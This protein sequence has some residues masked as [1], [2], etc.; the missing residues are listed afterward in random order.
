MS[1]TGYF[2]TNT[3][4]KQL[5][6]WSIFI[7]LSFIWGSSFILIKTGMTFLSPYN[8][9][10]IRII[11]SGI[12][13]LPITVRHIR[14]IPVSKLGLVFLSGVL[15]SLLPAYLFCAA[16]TKINSALAGMLNSLTPIFAI[17]CGALFFTSKVP[18][19]KVAGIVIAFAG[20]ILLLF[21]QGFKENSN[22]LYMCFAIIATIL[23]GININMVHKYLGNIRSLAIAS[24]ALSLCAIPATAVLFI[25]GFFQLPATSSKYVNSVVASVVLGIAGTAVATILF[26]ILVKRAG[27]IFSSMVTYGI[28]FIAILW[29]FVAH[30]N[31]TWKELA[32][33][34][35][36]LAGVYIANRSSKVIIG[37]QE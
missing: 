23:Y 4:N 32:S 18:A 22:I 9:A 12:V 31:I 25:S 26:Y 2:C 21:S 8:V 17:V 10:S 28:P 36:I 33:L 35:I 24:V 3:L 13:L 20:S 16:E 30:E 7:L 27:V 37:R 34:A 15:G 19:A 29:G 5:F 6:N 1:I 11:S 14:T